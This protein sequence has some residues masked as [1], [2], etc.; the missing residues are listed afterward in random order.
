MWPFTRKYLP[1]KVIIQLLAILYLGYNKM[2]II[3]KEDY[4]ESLSEVMKLTSYK[5]LIKLQNG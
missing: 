2:E 4:E 3:S 1:D 5:L